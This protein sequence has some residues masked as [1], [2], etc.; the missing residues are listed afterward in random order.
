MV[1]SIQ[2]SEKSSAEAVRGETCDKSISKASLSRKPMTSASSSD[3]PSSSATTPNRVG[4]CTVNPSRSKRTSPVSITEHKRAAVAVG[5][6]SAIANNT[7]LPSLSASNPFC[8]TGRPNANVAG[9]SN[10]PNSRSSV[11]D[12]GMRRN[13]ATPN[14]L[15][16]KF[17]QISRTGPAPARKRTPPVPTGSSANSTATCTARCHTMSPCSDAA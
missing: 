2:C 4:D 15:R 9:K 6:R 16:S 8:K 7:T 11:I 5:S 13:V 12:K 1:F 17:N 3:K 14:K 10:P